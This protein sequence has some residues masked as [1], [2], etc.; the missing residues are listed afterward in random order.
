MPDQLSSADL[1]RA[2]RPRPGLSVTSPQAAAGSRSEP[3]PSLP[4]ASGTQPAATAAAL[5][6]ELPAGERAVSHG[7]RLTVPGPSVVP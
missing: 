7:L 6:P 2:R 4:W 5:P 3:M 1:G